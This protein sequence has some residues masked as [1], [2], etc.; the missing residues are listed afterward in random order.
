[1]GIAEAP[2][3]ATGGNPLP[4]AQN[5]LPGGILRLDMN[6]PLSFGEIRQISA[7][8]VKSGQARLVVMRPD[9][10][11][12]YDVVY[13]TSVFNV[14][15]GTTQ[16]PVPRWWV[17]EGD[18]LGVWTSTDALGSIA[19]DRSQHLAV[20]RTEDDVVTDIRPHE[21]Q[22]EPYTIALWVDAK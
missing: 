16:I 21:S 20:R 9:G 3:R 18:R 14:E 1:M 7:H 17:L 11:G 10:R 15:P 4:A 19:S 12:G 8:W 22:V 5:A 2:P 6:N 13:R